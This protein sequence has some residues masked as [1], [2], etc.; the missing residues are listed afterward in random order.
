[1][2]P[3][4]DEVCELRLGLPRKPSVE[5]EKRRVKLAR[6]RRARGCGRRV[7][8][9]TR[10]ISLRQPEFTLLLSNIL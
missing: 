8:G 1:M 3:G 9:P 10:A 4:L 7:V 5:Q 2:L 6:W